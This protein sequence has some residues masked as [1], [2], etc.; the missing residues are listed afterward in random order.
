MG[1]ALRSQHK[2]KVRQPLAAIHLVTSDANERAILARLGDILCEELNVKRVLFGEREEELVTLSAKANFKTLGARLGKD[3]KR[4]AGLIEK[5]DSAALADLRA[6]G[7]CRLVDGELSAE[8]S[9]EDVLIHRSEREGLVVMNDGALTIAL[10]NTLSEE[11]ELE[12]LARDLVHQI[13]IMRKESGF[14]IT[15]RIRVYYAGDKRLS[16]AFDRFGAYISSEVL[17]V[18]LRSAE[19]AGQLQTYSFDGINAGL[20]V[21]RVI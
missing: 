5:M 8:I 18:E 19:G 9:A 17:A 16:A 11:L 14:A 10:D 4:A 7:H 12:G 3:M 1:R 15:D 2:I 13:Q 21:E 6:K 20:A